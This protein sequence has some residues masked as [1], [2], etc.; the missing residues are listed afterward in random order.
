[1]GAAVP[2]AAAVVPGAA[3]AADLADER[4][5]RS[6][7]NLDSNVNG[8]VMQPNIPT[9]RTGRY[10]TAGAGLVQFSWCRCKAG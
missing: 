5:C 1:M 6:I 2:A 4:M 3:A 9:D 10:A 8:L 7:T